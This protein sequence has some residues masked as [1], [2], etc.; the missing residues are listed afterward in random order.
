MDTKELGELLR[1]SEEVFKMRGGSKSELIEEQ[2]TMDFAFATVVSIKDI[3][4]GEKLSEDN[5]WVKRPGTGNIKAEHY[6]TLL[7]KVAIKDIKD[8]RHLTWEDFK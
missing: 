7:G 5:I 8:D 2:V 6:K 1:G 3:S 4:K